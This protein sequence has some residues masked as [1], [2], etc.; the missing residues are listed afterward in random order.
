MATKKTTDTL[1]TLGAVGVGI[2]VVYEIV[3]NLNKPTGA[4][5]GLIGG[6]GG[7][8]SYAPF[9]QQPQN[10]TVPPISFGASGS[11][12]GSSSKNSGPGAYDNPGVYESL[13]QAASGPYNPNIDYSSLAVL[14]NAAGGYDAQGNPITYPGADNTALYNSTESG[15]GQFDQ[16][17]VGNLPD[18]L[19]LNETPGA[20]SDSLS[21]SV[22]GLDQPSDD[23]SSFLSE[24]GDLISGAFGT[25]FYDTLT[26]NDTSQ[27]DAYGIPD[28]LSYDTGFD[29]TQDDSDSTNYDSSGDNTGDSGPGG[30]TGS[31]DSGG[32]DSGGGD[33]GGGDDGGGDDGGATMA[34]AGVTAAAAPRLTAP[35]MDRPSCR[36]SGPGR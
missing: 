12:G 13:T 10:P 33:D 3:K 6:G 16:V 19:L 35:A 28:A 32:S 29:P 15:L 1:W 7:S 2:I 26:G 27:S 11:G 25:G 9:G 8:D 31:G 34:V 17:P 4:P 5:S 21:S 36:R 18:S 23:G 30:D 22:G 24:V 14:V 20:P